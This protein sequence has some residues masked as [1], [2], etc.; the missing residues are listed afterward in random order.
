MWAKVI[1][2]VFMLSKHIYV[3]MQKLSYTFRDS[4]KGFIYIDDEN[5]LL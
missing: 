5:A 2:S 4:F 3:N 1:V